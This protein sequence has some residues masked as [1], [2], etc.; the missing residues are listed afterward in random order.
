M[1][2]NSSGVVDHILNDLLGGENLVYLSSD[3]TGQP[4]PGTEGFFG[5]LL[6]IV[7]NGNDTF[8]EK[9]FDFGLTVLPSDENGRKEIN[10]SDQ[11]TDIPPLAAGVSPTHQPSM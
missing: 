11:T 3:A 4:W 6:E 2:Q 7:F 1:H 9:S 5:V 8:L 10:V